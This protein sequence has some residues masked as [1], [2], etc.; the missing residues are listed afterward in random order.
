MLA[1]FFLLSNTVVAVVVAVSTSLGTTY[2]EPSIDPTTEEA[3][4]SEGFCEVSSYTLTEDPEYFTLYSGCL[5]VGRSLCSE[6]AEAEEAGLFDGNNSIR[7][8]YPNDSFNLVIHNTNL[9]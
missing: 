8:P 1:P 3:H 7:T 2:P 9:K 6:L 5:E 4:Q